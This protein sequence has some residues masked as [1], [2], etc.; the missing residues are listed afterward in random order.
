MWF[1]QGQLV[2]NRIT[3]CHALVYHA[4]E[5]LH[6]NLFL[7][8][9]GQSWSA[10]SVAFSC[11]NCYQKFTRNGQGFTQDKRDI[12]IQLN[13]NNFYFWLDNCHI[14]WWDDLDPPNFLNSKRNIDGCITRC[15]LLKKENLL[16]KK[17]IVNIVYKSEAYKLN[18][19]FFQCI[20]YLPPENIKKS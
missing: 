17:K 14:S 16:L 13:K 2:L 6:I 15:P 4:L 3:I 11:V 18:S 8:T 1:G 7:C 9:F 10:N 12:L 5:T 19:F 20:L